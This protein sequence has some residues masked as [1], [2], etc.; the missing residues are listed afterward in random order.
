MFEYLVVIGITLLSSITLVVTKSWHGHFS[1]DNSFGVQN[2]HIDPTPRI[3]GLAIALGLF[4][5]WVLVEPDV[6]IILGPMLL[7]SIPAFV[8]GLAE[9]ITKKIGVLPRLLAAMFSGILGW[10]LTGGI[11]QNTWLLPLDWLLSYLPFAVL[12]TAVSVAGLANAINIIDGFNGLAS[13]SVVIMSTALGIIALQFGDAPLASCCFI[14]SMCT[15]GFGIV[16][17]PMGK[18]FLGDGGAYLLGFLLAW[19]SVLLPVRNHEISS[20]S[21]LLVCAYPVL[22]VLFTVYRRR[23]RQGQHAAQPDKGH[24][25]HFI[26][27]RVVR[28]ALGHL[29]NKLQNSFT[30]PICWFFTAVPS[31]FAIA[32]S[33]DTPKL[34]LCLCLATVGYSMVYARLTQFRW[35]FRVLTLVHRSRPVQKS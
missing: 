32:F 1:L 16:N 21:P 14:L 30:S 26:H 24:L 20:W 8:V 31:T 12:F 23:K 6:R 7:A 11:I 2:H 29:S 19:F 35:C 3:G 15:I 28:R 22:E 9:D 25:H 34:I 5:A 4:V 33:T 10:Y 18:L 17:W 27:R 13:G